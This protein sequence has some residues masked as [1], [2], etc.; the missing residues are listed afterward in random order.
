MVQRDDPRP[1]IASRRSWETSGWNCG[2]NTRLL[3]GMGKFPDNVSPATVEH[4][5]AGNPNNDGC[6][7]ATT[8]VLGYLRHSACRMQGASVVVRRSQP[9][10]HGER[11]APVAS[12]NPAGDC[13]PG[14]DIV[15]FGDIRA[16]AAPNWLVA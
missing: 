4:A 3:G 5:A 9:E 8:T 14:L 10:C 15:K 6:Y 11:V 13:V 7:L 16:Q 12:L 2:P 1:A